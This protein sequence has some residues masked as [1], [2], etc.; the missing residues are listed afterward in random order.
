MSLHTRVRKVLGRIRRSFEVNTFDVFLKPVPDPSNFE[1][2]SGYSFR[3][4][5]ADDIRRC[6]QEHTELDERERTE[7]VARLGLDHRV[8]LGLVDELSVFSM[9]VNPRNFNVPGL[10]KR[11]LRKDQWF[12]YKAYTSPDHRGKSLYKTGLAF[13]LDAMSDEGLKELVGYAHRKKKVSRKGLSRLA[14]GKAGRMTR[15]D[16]PGYKHTFVSKELVANF[17]HELE[18]TNALHRT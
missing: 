7:G 3:W 13:V 18:R 9:W 14:F 2:P 17:P 16:F 5:T 1:Q 15:V 4:G 6:E 12:I 10:M 11:K 8:V